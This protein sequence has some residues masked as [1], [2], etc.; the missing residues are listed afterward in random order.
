MG[1]ARH[2]CAKT[3]HNVR[4]AIQRSTATISELAEQ[5]D[6]NPKTVM[7]W[8]QRKSV[9]DMPVGP[10]SPHLTVLSVEEE[11]LC[12]AFRKHTLLPIDGCLYRQVLSSIFSRSAPCQLISQPP[13]AARAIAVL[14]WAL[15]TLLPDKLEVGVLSDPDSVEDRSL[16]EPWARPEASLKSA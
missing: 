13:T 12:V 14:F 4:K 2:G 10:R 11:V 3:T 5:Y 16:H 15:P 1:Q 7:K 9:E 6:I 8:R